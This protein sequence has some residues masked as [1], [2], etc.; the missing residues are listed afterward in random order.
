M[1]FDELGE[2]SIDPSLIGELNVNPHLELSTALPE[3]PSLETD[4][5]FNAQYNFSRLSFV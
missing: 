2:A 5:D 3:L 1:T 4:L